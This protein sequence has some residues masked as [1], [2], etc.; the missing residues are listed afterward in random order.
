M[1]LEEGEQLPRPAEDALREH[2]RKG[3]RALWVRGER[4][5]EG[6]AERG[7]VVQLGRRVVLIDRLAL[8]LLLPDEVVVEAVDPRRNLARHGGLEARRG[9]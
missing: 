3:R 1:H 7:Q 8:A 4:L 9:G 2:E 5:R 6:A